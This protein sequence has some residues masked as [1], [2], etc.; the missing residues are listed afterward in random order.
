MSGPQAQPKPS[1]VPAKTGET[2]ATIAQNFVAKIEKQFQGE[3]GQGVNWTPL[4]QRLA[5]HLY[6]K[7]DGALKALESKRAATTYKKDDPP[8]SWDNVNL[9]KLAI[10]AVHRVNLGLDALIPNH[11]HVVPYLNKTTKKYDVDL[12]IGYMGEDHCH[13][14]FAAD[15]ILDI[16]YQLVHETDSFTYGTTPEGLAWYTFDQTNPFNPGEVIGG[17]GYIS[18]A[19]PRKNRI[20]IVE[21]RDFEKARAASRGVE[22]W[23]GIQT[24]WEKDEATGKNKKVEGVH[25]EKFRKEMQYKTLVRRVTARIPLDPTKVNTPSWSAV[26]ESRMDAIDAEAADVVSA[27]ANAEVLA[28]P[29]H[30][31]HADVVA[32]TSNGA[33][34]QMALVETKGPDF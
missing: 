29:E 14:K 3:L 27:H 23:G 8:I 6:I 17:F 4:E 24:A 32:P 13:R 28:I 33:Q 11:I 5:Q 34:E 16:R 21:Y 25:D 22:F 7:I 19:D 18:Y 31:E 20:V 30:A 2:T 10:D 1:S 15:E 9:P 26:L 12:M